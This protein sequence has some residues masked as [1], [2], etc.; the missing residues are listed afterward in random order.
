MNDQVLGLR[1]LL[2]SEHWLA[3]L[4]THCSTKYQTSGDVLF[5]AVFNLN[6]MRLNPTRADIENNLLGMFGTVRNIVRGWNMLAMP[7]TL[8]YYN[9]GEL[10]L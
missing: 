9:E 6:S 8:F 5:E 1:G 4:E 7:R 3:C 2:S 10:C